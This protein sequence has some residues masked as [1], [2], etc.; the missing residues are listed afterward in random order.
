M[1][2]FCIS[3]CLLIVMLSA[4]SAWGHSLESLL[5]VVRHPYFP[6]DITRAYV[7]AGPVLVILIIISRSTSTTIGNF[8][9]ISFINHKSLRI[10]GMPGATQVGGGGRERERNAKDLGFC[11]YWVKGGVPRVLRVHSIDKF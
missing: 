2:L 4:R 11:L 7:M 8:E 3:L 9:E 5:L 10:R 1:G 6:P